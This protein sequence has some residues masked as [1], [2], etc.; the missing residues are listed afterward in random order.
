M[1]PFTRD[2]GPTGA[3]LSS[4]ATGNVLFLREFAIRN[5]IAFNA[6]LGRT[7]GEDFDFFQR[8]YQLGAPP[9]YGNR[10]DAMIGPRRVVQWQC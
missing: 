7:G 9:T 2:Y 1:D 4:I 8:S 5:G 3:P 10:V 6:E